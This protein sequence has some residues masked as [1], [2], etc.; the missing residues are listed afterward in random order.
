MS[1]DP[2]SYD[3]ASQSL[4]VADKK[5]APSLVKSRLSAHHS[6]TPSESTSSLFHAFR[7]KKRPTATEIPKT[8]FADVRLALQPDSGS[9]DERIALLKH[10]AELSAQY[11]ARDINFASL[12]QQL[13]FHGH[14]A[15]YWAIV[16]NPGPEEGPFDLVGTVVRFSG[17]L[18]RFTDGRGTKG[19]GALPEED[20]FLLN[21][22]VPPEEIKLD[23]MEGPD[24]PFSVKF[25]IPMYKKRMML[26]RQ[27]KLEFIARER[28]WCLSF[29]TPANSPLRP[30][31]GSD[32]GFFEKGQW[33]A[34][35]Q[36]VE[37]M[38]R[39][40]EMHCAMVVMDQ[41][42]TA[43]KPVHAWSQALSN[44]PLQG[45]ST[46]HGKSG[47]FAF[48]CWWAI[49]GDG[50]QG[51]RSCIAEDGSITGIL[52]VKLSRNTTSPK[53]WPPADIPTKA[54]AECIVC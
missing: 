27:I 35:I 50:P 2:P 48:A 39:S 30:K 4:D 26:A 44:E 33:A 6:S 45:G 54:D 17:P 53:E 41:P 37:S 46:P 1:A 22:L 9:V 47:N 36:L 21:T 19:F 16:N 34:S 49:F 11:S 14:T 3:S 5:A 28:M 20:R 15:L 32:A 8:I 24:Q 18:N 7:K 25:K 42:N 29:F 23:L 31:D 38:S 13:D 43:R 12:L 51:E 10:C 52:G 40:T